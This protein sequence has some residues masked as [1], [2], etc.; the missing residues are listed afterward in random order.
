MSDNLRERIVRLEERQ[1][2][3]REQNTVE[4]SIR[5]TRDDQIFKRLD[6]FSRGLDEVSDAQIAMT[7][8]LHKVEEALDS[9]DDDL[10]QVQEAVKENTAILQRMDGSIRT[11]KWLWPVLLMILSTLV[12]VFV[13]NVY[14][15]ADK[16]A[17]EAVEKQYKKDLPSSQSEVKVKD[18]EHK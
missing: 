5:K 8:K 10:K 3:D 9:N 1:R 6:S 15:T 4:R 13:N 18:E 7:G 14:L 11:L 12:T 16:K 17:G 2:A